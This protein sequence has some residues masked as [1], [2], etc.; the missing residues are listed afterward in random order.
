MH[1][2]DTVLVSSTIFSGPSMA[3]LDAWGGTVCIIP[4][5]SMSLVAP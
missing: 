3:Q 2:H 4:A 5:W 1:R